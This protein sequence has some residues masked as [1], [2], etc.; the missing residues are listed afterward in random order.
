MGFLDNITGGIK[1]EIEY[2]AGRG[3]TDAFRK[4]VDKLKGGNTA[5]K[6]KCPK[7]GK[8]VLENAKVCGQ[9]GTKLMLT[10]TQ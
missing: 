8:P 9:C 6:N 2:N 10:C 7:C 1:R 3:V 4:G 5:G